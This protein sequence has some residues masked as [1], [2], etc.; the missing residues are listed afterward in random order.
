MAINNGMICR[1]SWK[2]MNIV[3]IGYHGI[4]M[5]VGASMVQLGLSF[6][7]IFHYGSAKKTK[8]RL[9]LLSLVFITFMIANLTGLFL[10]TA[11]IV[12]GHIAKS[13]PIGRLCFDSV[14]AIQNFLIMLWLR[15]KLRNFN[16]EKLR[17]HVDKV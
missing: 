16:N 11:R 10:L 14:V 5:I 9:R 17:I 4:Y 15:G 7:L 6:D 8:R 12:C 13:L 2:L 3:E 1:K